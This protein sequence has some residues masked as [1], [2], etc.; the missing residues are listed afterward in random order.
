MSSFPSSALPDSDCEWDF[1]WCD[2]AWLRKYFDHSYMEEHV[3][4]NHFHN[5]Y[6]VSRFHL[7]TG[8]NNYDYAMTRQ[9]SPHETVKRPRFCLFL[10]FIF[11]LTRKN[12]TVKN[13]KR[14]RKNLERD[15]GR[16]EAAKCDFFP[17]TFTLPSEYHIFVE[18]FKRTPGST[19]I[20]KPVSSC[21]SKIT[22]A[23]WRWCDFDFRPWTFLCWA[24][25]AKSQGKGIF[26]FRKL[27]D[28]MDWKK[29]LWVNLPKVVSTTEMLIHI[30]CLVSAG[31][32]L[33]RRAEGRG[34]SGELRGATLH[35]ESLSN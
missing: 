19:W 31:R 13:L 5:N 3:R 24:Q 18:E 20:M 10:S 16:S 14:L 6:E 17:R 1:N 9:L 34:S 27:K 25:A 35:W 22:P 2:G 15:A 32:R 29:V 4:I 11:Q 28:I 12:L 21:C 30:G 26:L 8:L 23:V 7:E 33:F